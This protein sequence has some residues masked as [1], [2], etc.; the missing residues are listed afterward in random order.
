MGVYTGTPRTWSTGETVTPALMNSDTR[1]PIKALSDAMTSYSPS[2][3]A[4]TSNPA[5]GNGTITG[6]YTRVGK[7][8]Q[9]WAA[10]TMGS[11]TTYGS[12]QWRLT[13][14]A[15]P[16]GQLWNF[17]VTYRDD[18]LAARYSGNAIWSTSGYVE[19][20]APATTAGNA[21]RSVSSTVPFTWANLDNVFVH[22]T[23][24]AA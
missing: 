8:V 14:P 6:A 4:A 12:G 2:W 11:T 16:T 22:G 18:S 21:D 13:L 9:F 15:T 17:V 24:S 10:V 5:I 19:L 23:Y 7:F 20:F 1:D 3:T